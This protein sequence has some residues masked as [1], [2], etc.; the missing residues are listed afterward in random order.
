[1]S[2]GTLYGIGVGPG[3]PELITLKAA[4]RITACGVVASLSTNGQPGLARRIAAAHIG[5]HQHELALP[6]PMQATVERRAQA[7]DDA[8]ATLV[9]YLD[10]GDD[11][12][13]LCEGDPLLYGSFIAIMKRLSLRYRCEV[14]PG[15]SSIMAGAAAGLVPL[16]EAQSTFTIVPATLDA[17][18][19][20]DVI[21]SADGVAILK[22]GRH[23][24]KVRNL[25]AACGR[26]DTAL[27]VER[28]G[29]SEGRCQAF[30]DVAPADVPYFALVLSPAPGAPA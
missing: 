29:Q 16:A 24:Q 4:R 3:D 20:N 21:A 30:A 23:A 7:Y 14:I 22:L 8:V 13:V 2:A 1:M 6:M 9:P 5:A 25:L 28:I 10:R 18:R 19:L 17:P 12:A 27:Y 26:L 15:I 11:V